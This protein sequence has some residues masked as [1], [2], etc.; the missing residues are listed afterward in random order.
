MLNYVQQF[1]KIRLLFHTPYLWN[2]AGEPQFLFH[3]WNKKIIICPQQ[4]FKKILPSRKFSRE[5]P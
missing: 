5:R 4:K 1:V 3:F 2:E